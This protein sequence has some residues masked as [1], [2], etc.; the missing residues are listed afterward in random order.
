V[1]DIL[2]ARYTQPPGVVQVADEVG[3]HP[4]HL[5]RVFRRTY[6]CSV[7]E[8]VRRL[9]VEFAC[10]EL[11]RGGRSLAAIALEAG[12]CDQSQFCHT[13]KRHVG[14]TPSQFRRQARER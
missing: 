7:G 10:R 13:F 9:R 6:G 14:I 3:V 12:F 4:L 11:T 8:Y 1:R 2:H 5:A